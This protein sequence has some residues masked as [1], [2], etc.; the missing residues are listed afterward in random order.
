MVRGLAFL[1]EPKCTDY[2][3]GFILDHLESSS[4]LWAKGSWKYIGDFWEHLTSNK[5]RETNAFL[6]WAKGKLYCLNS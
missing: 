2:R 4:L 6:L 1:S 3:P 5:C